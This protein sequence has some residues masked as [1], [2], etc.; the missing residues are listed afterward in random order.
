MPIHW[1]CEPK[2]VCVCRASL[3]VRVCVC[4]CVRVCACVCVRL[5]FQ[6]LVLERSP[7]LPPSGTALSLWGNAWLALDRLGVADRLRHSYC[8]LL[9]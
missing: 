7:S 5:G 1:L 6:V 9:G 4:A 2:F 3:V 8:R